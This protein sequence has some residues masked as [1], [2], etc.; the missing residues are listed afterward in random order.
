MITWII[1]EKYSRE[2]ER[3]SLERVS[4]ALVKAVSANS[5]NINYP[6]LTC[7]YMGYK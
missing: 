4:G 7:V 2:S 1:E 3:L 5:H 6:H